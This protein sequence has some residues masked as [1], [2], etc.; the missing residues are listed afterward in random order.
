MGCPWAHPVSVHFRVSFGHILSLQFKTCSRTQPSWLDYQ[1]MSKESVG[2]KTSI[3]SWGKYH[4]LKKIVTKYLV[5]KQTFRRF[6][7]VVFGKQCWQGVREHA[8]PILW[9]ILYFPQGRAVLGSVLG[10]ASYI[11]CCSAVLPGHQPVGSIFLWFTGM[12]K[13][14][15]PL[16]HF[17]FFAVL[18][19]SDFGDE[20]KVRDTVQAALCS[21]EMFFLTKLYA[22]SEPIFNI[23]QSLLRQLRAKLCD[24]RC[25]TQFSRQPCKSIS[26]PI[27]LQYLYV[28]WDSQMSCHHAMG[29]RDCHRL[30]VTPGKCFTADAVAFNFHFL[31][32]SSEVWCKVRDKWALTRNRQHLTR[33]LRGLID[34]LEDE[35]CS[36]VG[37][38]PKHWAL[39]E[40]TV[41][42]NPCFKDAHQNVRSRHLLP[43]HY[44]LLSWQILPSFSVFSGTSMKAFL[45]RH[46]PPIKNAFST[47]VTLKSAC[48]WLVPSSPLQLPVQLELDVTNNW[49]SAEGWSWII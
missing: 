18:L 8:V 29:W 12:R 33:S 1:S 46:T 42:H 2:K 38:S 20:S 40:L 11:R 28:S 45:H 32:V 37:W 23:S 13:A 24:N 30:Y 39:C 25:W 6:N 44:E 7:I 3:A 49:N 43:E 26:I 48:L 16:S 4:T 34:Q 9:F 10:Q 14:F 5:R 47:L 15:P 41:Q 31:Y 19:V 27:H 21:S 22:H 17:T 36:G 35:F